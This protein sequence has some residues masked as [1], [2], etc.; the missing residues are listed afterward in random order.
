MIRRLRKKSR[1]V[2]SVDDVIAILK[3]RALSKEEDCMR[4]AGLLALKGEPK[5][6]SKEELLKDLLEVKDFTKEQLK[7]RGLKIT[8]EILR[9]LGKIGYRSLLHHRAPI[10]K[11]GA[12]SWAP[13]H[14]MDIPYTSVG[15][16]EGGKIWDNFLTINQNGTIEV[17]WWYRALTQK[18]CDSGLKPCERDPKADVIDAGLRSWRN[19]ILLRENWN[20]KGEVVLVATVGKEP[21][22][23]SRNEVIDCHYLGPVDEKDDPRPAGG[24]MDPRFRFG[25]IR[26]GNERGRPAIDARKLLRLPPASQM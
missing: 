22:P 20:E 8:C 6:E 16:L 3:P 15:D 25:H 5:E 23:G 18:D 19:C 4:C 7:V 1:K 24:S 10:N 26:L 2:R 14:L 11:T 21:V 12:F 17:D 9:N 13:E